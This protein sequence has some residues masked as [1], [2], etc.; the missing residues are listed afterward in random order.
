[1]TSKSVKKYFDIHSH[2]HPYANKNIFYHKPIIDYIKNDKLEKIQNILDVGCGD[3]FFFQTLINEGIKRNF[4]GTDISQKMIE[5]TKLNLKNSCELIVADML[6]TPFKVDKFFD[7]IYAS[8]ILHHLIGKTRLNSFQLAENFLTNLNGVLSKNG[9]LIIE[10][11]S[12]DSYFIPSFIS[13][14]IFYGLKFLNFFKID[15]SKITPEIQS[16]LEVNFFYHD[17]LVKMLQRYGTVKILRDDSRKIS[18]FKRLLS[19]KKLRVTTFLVE[20]RGIT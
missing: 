12:Y 7:I 6:Y 8:F 11:I 1:M 9:V 10:E 16:G 13:S 19:L 15:L 2:H 4:F 5:T 14:I 3:G 20:S 17:K 18:K